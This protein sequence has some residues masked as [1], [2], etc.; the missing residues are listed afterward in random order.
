MELL[1]WKT[2]ERRKKIVIALIVGVL[3]LGGAYALSKSASER[4]IYENAVDNQTATVGDLIDRDTDKDGVPD[5]EET[6]WG[7]NPELSDTDGDGTLDRAEVDALRQAAG[8]PIEPDASEKTTETDA[9]ARQLFA[10][11]V[12]LKSSGEL[13]PENIQSLSNALLTE[14]TA[15]DTGTLYA[16]KD[17]IIR[18]V[19][20]ESR[21]AYADGLVRI[22]ERY[23]KQPVV[24]VIVTAATALEKEDKT[25]LEA[26]LINAKLYKEMASELLAL[27]VPEDIATEHLSMINSYIQISLGIRNIEQILDNPVVGLSGLVAHEQGQRKLAEITGK[28]TT[29][30][31]ANG[32]ILGKK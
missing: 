20:A 32:I 21:A 7:T 8:V 15:D 24:S 4:R 23:G 30:F 28:I 10:S 9:F 5:W 2:I 3:I 18:P 14:V 6:L 19:S 17:L 22:S 29:Y 27:P 31:S 1:R 25:I 26:I 13:T 11:I 16:I 12:S